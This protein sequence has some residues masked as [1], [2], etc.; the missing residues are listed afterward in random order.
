MASDT[1]ADQYE[2]KLLAQSEESTGSYMGYCLCRLNQLG[3]HNEVQGF[4]ACNSKSLRSFF[5][6]FSART[7][8]N[9]DGKPCAHLREPVFLEPETS[10]IDHALA[11]LAEWQHIISPAFRLG[12]GRGEKIQT[13]TYVGHID[14]QV[15]ANDFDRMEIWHERKWH[16]VL[17]SEK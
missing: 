13:V 4:V 7:S 1:C 10:D 3:S 11:V 12:G 9:L 17:G 5:S 6:S 15:V 14:R 16:Q 2:P 8:P